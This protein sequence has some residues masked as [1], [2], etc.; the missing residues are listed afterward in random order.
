MTKQVAI[1]GGGAGG[2]VTAK[3]LKKQGFEPIIF[4]QSDNIG[5]QWN[6][7]APHSGVWP[8]MRTN[9]SRVMTSF[10]DLKHAPSTGVYPSNQQMFAYLQRYAANFDLIPHI[11]LQT[12]I[13]LIERA[14]SDNG[15]KVSFVTKD[16]AA[17]TENFPYVVVASG[18]YNKPV[19]PSVPGI[20]S[21]SGC[22]GVIHTFHYK[23]PDR[24]RGQRVLV[25][26]CS[27]SALEIASDLAMR[28]AAQVVSTF[29]RQR[30]IFHKLLAGV[31]TDHV[32]F[33]RFAALAEE[34]MPMDVLAQG[35]K[36]LVLRTSGSPEQFGA[37][38][39]ADNIFEAGVSQC[40]YY[41]PL[42]AEGRIMPKPWISAI[43]GQTVH[44]ADGSMEEVDA[45]IFGTGYEL[46]IPFLS[47]EIRRVL[48]LDTHHIDLYK[49]TFHPDLPGLAFLGMFEQIGPYFPVLEL[50]ARW[51]AYVWSGILPA[52]SSE[53]MAAGLA[54]Y[55]SRRGEPQE[56][57]MH[58]MALLFSRQI[59]VEPELHKW[60]ELARA[61]LFGPLASASFRLCG[62]DSLPEAVEHFT[63]DALAFGVI[64]SVEFTPEQ[65]VQLQ[66]LSAVYNDNTFAEFVNQLTQ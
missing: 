6:G 36:E 31:P 65:L 8:S 30:Y 19:I 25:A 56:Q 33:T 61:L 63:A 37:Y 35:F 11:R 12:G 52:P 13:K 24:Y 14:P 45:I 53:E 18:R 66:A 44:F 41:L 49:F 27:I 58:L 26:G 17:Q 3:Y 20:E 47:T 43:E 4:E 51:I 39:P 42:V 60:P 22:G 16:G 50:Q 34:V 62:F 7:R 5:G 64:P 40:Q 55:R 23:D 21:F 57:F 29:R 38:K 9:T 2:L 32:V 48:D 59:G 10:S 28:G 15:W 46:H 1:V 54:A